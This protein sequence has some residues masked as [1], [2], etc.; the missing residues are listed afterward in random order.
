MPVLLVLGLVLWRKQTDIRAKCIEQHFDGMPR[1]V[2]HTR[3]LI[4]PVKMVAQEFFQ[5]LL[6]QPDFLTETDQ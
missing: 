5:F 2:A 6:F 1:F 4:V 3:Y